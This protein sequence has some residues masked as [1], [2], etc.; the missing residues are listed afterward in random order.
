MTREE[1][2]E[3]S[4][5]EE[6]VIRR[7]IKLHVLDTVYG[8]KRSELDYVDA[9]YPGV[10][11][12]FEIDTCIEAL[13]NKDALRTAFEEKYSSDIDYDTLKAYFDNAAKMCE[14]TK[15]EEKLLKIYNETISI[16]EKVYNSSKTKVK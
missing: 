5:K 1:L 13:E 4:K 16:M 10:E 11:A 14:R 6:D 12:L 15:D 8:N 7:I 2:Y 3:K 9:L